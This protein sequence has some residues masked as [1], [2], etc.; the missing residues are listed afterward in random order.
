MKAPTHVARLVLVSL[1]AAVSTAAA[2]TPLKIR[3]GIHT[4]LMGAPDV[5][6]I[7]QE[8]FNQ[9]HPV[10]VQRGRHRRSARRTGDAARDGAAILPV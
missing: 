2:Q 4:S 1:S 8:Y 9:E 7:R 3:L 10:V 5:I 6:A